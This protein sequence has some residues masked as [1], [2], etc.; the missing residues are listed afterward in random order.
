MRSIPNSCRFGRASGTR[1]PAVARVEWLLD[2][3]LIDEEAANQY[4]A[5]HPDPELP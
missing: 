4:F 5:E 3:S 2:H 1:G